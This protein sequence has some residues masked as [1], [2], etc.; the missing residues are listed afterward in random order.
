MSDL[1]I[2]APEETPGRKDRLWEGT[3]LELFLGAKGSEAYREFN[4]SPSGNWNV[5]RFTSYRAGMLEE[6]AFTSLPFAVR[7][8]QDALELSLE[9]DVGKILPKN[10]AIEAGVA[11]VVKT[12]KGGTSYWA[13]A[14]PGPRPD[15]HR[16]E[17][18]A[19]TIP[20]QA[21]S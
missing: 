2:P 3:C 5:F 4:L 12:V 7:I 9:L 6:E 10:E 11:V 8:G 14:H 18:F 16:R 19:L 15:F 13:L 17:G 21:T 1:A 20:C